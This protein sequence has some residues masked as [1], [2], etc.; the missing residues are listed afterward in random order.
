M[1]S[2]LVALWSTLLMHPVHETVCEIEWNAES[3][4]VEVALRIDVLDEQWMAR[5]IQADADEDWQGQY[6]R[7]KLF[8]DPQV[9][10]GERAEPEAAKPEAV[11]LSGRPIRWV[12]RKLDGGH[13]WW[14]FEVVCQDGQPPTSIQTRLLFDRQR[15]YQHRIVVLGKPVADDGKRVSILLTDQ[16]PSAALTLVR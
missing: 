12:G 7:S 14:F 11:K 3:R 15:D 8:F 6:L 13:V 5:S 9:G 4:R 10:Q 16:K 1:T 2:V